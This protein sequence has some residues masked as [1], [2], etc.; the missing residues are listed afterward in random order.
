MMSK[1]TVSRIKRAAMRVTDVDHYPD[2]P[3]RQQAAVWTRNVAFW[4]ARRTASM[5]TLT[6]IGEAF[7]W[8]TMHHTTVIHALN[9][10][11]ERMAGDPEFRASVHE[12]VEHCRRL[13]GW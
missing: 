10:C 12:A 13:R 9:R 4:I 2:Y 6:G 5:E 8:P 1:T 11:A 7:G 3:G